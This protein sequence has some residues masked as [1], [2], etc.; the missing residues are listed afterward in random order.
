MICRVLCFQYYII[1]FM[2]SKSIFTSTST[3]ELSP[4][5]YAVIRAYMLG[6]SEETLMQLL[7]LDKFEIKKIW[8]RL[9][10]KYKRNNI[11]V[12]I[13]KIIQLGLIEVDNYLP[14]TVK[15]STLEFINLHHN[16]FPLQSPKSEGEKWICYH[17]LLKYYSFLER[18]EKG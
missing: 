13:R 10:E 5:E 12:L 7:Q 14:E 18:Y 1:L 15:S 2:N 9:F 17:F 16:Q 3:S 8:N 4:K 6:L 11:Y